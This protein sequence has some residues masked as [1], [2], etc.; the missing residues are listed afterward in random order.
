MLIDYLE[1]VRGCSALINKAS[2]LLQYD[3]LD[4]GKYLT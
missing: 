2:K 3:E 4:R 1:L